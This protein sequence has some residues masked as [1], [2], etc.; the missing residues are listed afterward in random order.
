[1]LLL[2]DRTPPPRSERPV[3]DPD[4]RTI[5]WVAAAIGAGIASNAT[6]AFVAFLLLCVAV[7]C[8]GHAINRALPW[9]DGLRE[10]RQ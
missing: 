6:H 7:G 3:W 4:W 9:G 1:M 10:Y 2:H 5:G 8:A